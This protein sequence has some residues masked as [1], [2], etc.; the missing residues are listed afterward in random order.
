M[1]RTTPIWAEF[2]LSASTDVGGYVAG[3]GIDYMVT[4]NFVI[5]LEY[6]YYRFNVG[7][8]NGLTNTGG[9]VIACAFCNTSESVRTSGRARQTSS[10]APDGTPRA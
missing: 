7:A 9:V 10:L 5:G 3:G 4:Q 8:F 2:N 1:R 6:D